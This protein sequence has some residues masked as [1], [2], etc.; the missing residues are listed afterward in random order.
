MIGKDFYY[1]GHLLSEYGLIMAKPDEDQSFITRSIIGTEQSS[2]RPI[3]NILGMKY[4]ET[5][6]LRFF[7]IK[8]NCHNSN[9]KYSRFSQTELRHIRRWLESPK[10][11]IELKM[12]KN[13]DEENICYFGVFTDVQPFIVG[14]D[15]YGLNLTFQCNAPYGFSSPYTEVFDCPKSTTYTHRY[16]CTNDEKYEYVYPVIKLYLNPSITNKGKISIKNITDNN[17]SLSINIPNI[18]Y[19]IIDSKKKQILDPN[20][21]IM[22]LCDLGINT[23]EIFDYSSIFNG[24][25]TVKWP[26]LLYGENELQFDTSVLNSV[27]KIELTTRFVRKVDG[28]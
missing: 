18:S 15:C 21:T 23:D 19:I 10:A 5:L 2:K 28:F 6:P 3:K 13:T 4:D 12:I 1:D 8:D 22:R 25:L 26:R 7:I 9:Q 24:S 27:T 20:G 17:S 14:S 11:A 16:V